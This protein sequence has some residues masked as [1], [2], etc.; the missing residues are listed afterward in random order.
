MFRTFLLFFFFYFH[1][2]TSVTYFFLYWHF[3]APP[4]IEPF[5]FPEVIE[6]GARSKILCSVTKGDSPITIQWLKDGKPLAADLDVTENELDEFSKVLFFPR[7]ELRHRGN[8]TCIARNSAASASYTAAM[9]IHGMLFFWH[10]DCDFYVCYF[11]IQVF[12]FKF[13]LLVYYFEMFAKKKKYFF[14]LLYFFIF[15]CRNNLQLQL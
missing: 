13:S 14:Y 4:V 8:Y 15:K 12:F 9:V 2:N 10:V 5:A 1:C 6:E 3:S 11:R 7:V